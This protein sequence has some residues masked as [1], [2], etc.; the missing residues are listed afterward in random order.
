MEI[1]II[2]ILSFIS[3]SLIYL[4]IN[5]YLD[6]YKHKTSNNNSNYINNTHLSFDE[7]NKI[8]ENIIDDVYQNKYYINY[9]LREITI[10]P[11]MDE[12]ISNCVK[13]ITNAI[14]DKVMIELLQY[15]KYD[16]IIIRITRKVQMLF[17]EYTNTFKPNTK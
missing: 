14:G 6:R 4:F 10:I 1:F 15:Y 13:D 12:E 7:C 2:C 16:Y 17:I 8:V 9:R 5:L 11:K 3:S